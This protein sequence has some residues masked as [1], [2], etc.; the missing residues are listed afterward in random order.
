[1]CS[2]R[3]SLDV[4]EL[5]G[6]PGLTAQLPRTARGADAHVHGP[7]TRDPIRDCRCSG[8][9]HDSAI[10]ITSSLHIASG[11]KGVTFFH[12]F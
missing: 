12:I 6:E 9:C 5:N 3:R 8:A 7:G 11:L 2:H 10:F 4:E 1:M